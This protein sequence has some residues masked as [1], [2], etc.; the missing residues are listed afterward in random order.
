[1]KQILSYSD[2]ETY[3]LMPLDSG[4]ER[5]IKHHLNLDHPMFLIESDCQ[6]YVWNYGFVAMVVPYV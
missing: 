1:M 3:R 2:L 4:E 6:I 5:V